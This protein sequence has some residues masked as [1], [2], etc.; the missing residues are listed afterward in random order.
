MAPAAASRRA[1][2]WLAEVEPL[3]TLRERAAFLD[4]AAGNAVARDRLEVNSGAERFAVRLAE[5]Q[6][7]RTYGQS[8]RAVAD[9]RLPA[10]RSLDRLELY[11]NK[12]R[13][14]TLYQAPWALPVA[15]PA[16]GAVGYVRAVAYLP[17]GVAAEDVV[18]VNT[19]GFGAEVEVRLVELYAAVFDRAGRPIDGLAAEQFRIAE[20]GAPQR[21]RRF[22]RVRDLP[23]AAGLLLDT[24]GS[25]GPVLQEVR[26][27]AAA[28]LATLTPRDRAALLTFNRGPRLEVPLTGERAAL[29]S[30]LS[31]LVAQNKT[32]LYDSVIFGLRTLADAPGQRALLLLSDGE[33]QGSHFGFE[34]ALDVARR[35]GV[36][37]Y[38]IGLG[39]RQS[40][41]R[42]R[43][44]RLAAETGGRAFFPGDAAELAGIYGEIERELRSRYLLAYESSHGE[45]GS[46]FRR[47]EV[48]LARPDLEARTISGYYP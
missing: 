23:L 1:A 2:A 17:D 33:E 43:L 20:D 46:D 9:V 28:F 29:T 42:K 44:A 7:G 8:L 3:I 30:G 14:A 32:A 4:D 31:S 13:I 24:S 39:A 19:P 6:A 15:L 11:W 36:A 37:L 41:A 5:P 45:A 10:G 21:V 25:M 16:P 40:E 34:P 27:A 47:V 12:E 26:A 18:Q 48:E 35:S 22:E 38:A